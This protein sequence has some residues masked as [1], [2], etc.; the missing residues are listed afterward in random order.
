MPTILISNFG[1]F[2]PSYAQIGRSLSRMVNSYRLGTTTAEKLRE[3][4]KRLW[5][6]RKRLQKE[7]KG[8]A[9]WREWRNKIW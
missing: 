2:K 5:P 6:I 9:T 1:T 4:V 3:Q 8:I 7:K